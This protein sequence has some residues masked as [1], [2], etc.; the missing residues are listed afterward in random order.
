[1]AA[2]A[3]ALS[4]PKTT[5]VRLLTTSVASTGLTLAV[6]AGLDDSGR[7]SGAVVGAVATGCGFACSYVMGRRWVLG[8][9]GIGHLTPLLWLGGLSLAGLLLCA[10]GAAA[11]DL[12]AAHAHLGRGATLATEEAA[13]SLVLGALF[14]V[15]L[16]VC[17][18]LLGALGRPGPP[19]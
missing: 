15:R 12:G 2:A 19:W 9:A 1:M 16:A 4:R 3:S 8:G 6:V 17:R 10:A 11:A 18:M 7:L 13:E 14:A 5:T